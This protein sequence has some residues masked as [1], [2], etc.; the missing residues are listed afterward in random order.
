MRIKKKEEKGAQ[1]NVNGKPTDVRIQ[2]LDAGNFKLRLMQ[3]KDFK[4]VA[5]FQDNSL[6]EQLTETKLKELTTQGYTF[7]KGRHGIVGFIALDKSSERIIGRNYLE[8]WHGED[9]AFPN[10]RVTQTGGLEV[11]AGEEIY[12]DAIRCVEL[13]GWLVKPE[14][15]GQG[16]G[17]ALTYM[18]TK[19]VK[20]LHDSY[21]P[22]DIA[23]VSC[24]GQ[25]RPQDNPEN[26]DFAKRIYEAI[27]QNVGAAIERE[28]LKDLVGQGEVLSAK[29]LIK[30]FQELGDCYQLG[31]VREQTASAHRISERLIAQ[32]PLISNGTGN[33]T[34]EINFQKAGVI[35][36]ALGTDYTIS[37]LS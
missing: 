33:F 1:I 30:I 27:G 29:E 8:T 24:V 7:E 16:L 3:E 37:Y 10:Y 21:C 36:P 34:S 13:G 28:D 18:N 4:E 25:F 6:T 17:K 2:E 31:M 9:L 15:R 11:I 32:L 26:I 22:I 14:Y 20:D 19:F 23:L 12:H 35:H 5:S